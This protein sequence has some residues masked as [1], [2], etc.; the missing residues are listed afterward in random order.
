[1]IA[2]GRISTELPDI[3]AVNQVLEASSNN[4]SLFK[5]AH[6]I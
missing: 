4:L 5:P 1:V 3:F 2:I 6:R